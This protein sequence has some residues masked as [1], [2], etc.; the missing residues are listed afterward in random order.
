MPQGV[1]CPW[2]GTLQPAARSFSPAGSSLSSAPRPV[3]HLRLCCN[4]YFTHWPPRAG[5]HSPS[6]LGVDTD[7]L[8]T[9]PPAGTQPRGQVGSM[10]PRTSYLGG[11]FVLLLPLPARITLGKKP[12]SQQCLL[13]QTVGAGRES[14]RVGE[15]EPKDRGAGSQTLTAGPVGTSVLG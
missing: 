6:A 9:R 13:G 8:G 10:A 4:H 15:A 14:G 3:P 2:R 12:C 1:S 11:S 5:T 7:V